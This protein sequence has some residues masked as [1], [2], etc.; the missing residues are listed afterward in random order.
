MINSLMENQSYYKVSPLVFLR[1][2][3]K[4]YGKAIERKNRRIK[5]RKNLIT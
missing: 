3:N 1:T 2:Q 5:K 4:N